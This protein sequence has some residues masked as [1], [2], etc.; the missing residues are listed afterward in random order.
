MTKKDYIAL[1]NEFGLTYYADSSS[2]YYKEFP[3]CGYRADHS[4]FGTND[5]DAKSLIIFDNY[6]EVLNNSGH[7]SGFYTNKYATK[8]EE[9]RLLIS[10]QIMVVKNKCV[11]ERL[12]KMYKDFDE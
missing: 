12:E 10:N 6:D 3:I 4:N 7:Y 11:N 8:V 2:A 9:A 5:L 1:V